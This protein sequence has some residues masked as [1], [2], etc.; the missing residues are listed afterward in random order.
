MAR[1]VLLNHGGFFVR[2]KS[3]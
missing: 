1:K 3:I 2:R